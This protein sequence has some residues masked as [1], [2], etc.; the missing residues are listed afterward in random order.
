MAVLDC[1]FVCTVT[2]MYHVILVNMI[3]L[4]LLVKEP[5]EMTVFGGGDFV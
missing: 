1:A 3:V 4:L 2:T 5:I